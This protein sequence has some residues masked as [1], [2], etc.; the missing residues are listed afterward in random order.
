MKRL[1][2]YTEIKKTNSEW[3]IKFTYISPFSEGLWVLVPRYLYTYGVSFHVVKLGVVGGSCVVEFPPQQLPMEGE[4]WGRL[5]NLLGEW[6]L[7]TLI[8]AE[9]FL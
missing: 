9:K 5:P 6:Q 8:I 3:S 4:G 2:V 1:Y 7:V